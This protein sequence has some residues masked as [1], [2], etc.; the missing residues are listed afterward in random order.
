MNPDIAK[1]LE[2]ILDKRQQQKPAAINSVAAQQ[3]AEEKNLAEFAAK[4]REVILPAF[5]EIIDLYKQ[6]GIELLILEENEKPSGTGGFPVPNIR[7][8]MKEAYPS[9]PGGERHPE[10]RLAFDKHNR[11]V[12]LY[13]STPQQR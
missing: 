2:S 4:K 13:T 7:L 5:Q 12:S 10:F 6:R 3:T 1:Q 9:H 8:D 11:Q